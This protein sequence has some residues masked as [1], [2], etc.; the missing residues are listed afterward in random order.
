MKNIVVVTQKRAVEAEKTI[1]PIF[2]VLTL[3][4]SNK[5]NTYEKL[6]RADFKKIVLLIK[7]SR[8]LM[9]VELLAE[10]CMDEYDL[11]LSDARCAL[12]Y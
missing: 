12:Y 11:P 4:S 6:S 1:T 3:K 10:K 9:D 2:N 7:D 5:K 8:C